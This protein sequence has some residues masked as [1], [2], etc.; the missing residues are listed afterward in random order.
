M[1]RGDQQLAELVKITEAAKLIRERGMTLLA[2][3]G[4]TYSNV[5]PIAGIPGMNELN[6]GHSIVSRAIMVGFEK[7][8]ADMKQLVIS[9]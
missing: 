1:C 2:G 4:L 9:A 3:H 7:A 8:V 6:I 5:R